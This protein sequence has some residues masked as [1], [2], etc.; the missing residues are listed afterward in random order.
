M[1]RLAW[2]NVD[3]PAF[4][5]IGI[6][7]VWNWRGT[8]GKANGPRG[9]RIDVRGRSMILVTSFGRAARSAFFST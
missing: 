8:V 2:H 1:Q 3:K 7:G 6:P 5:V 4:I 9:E